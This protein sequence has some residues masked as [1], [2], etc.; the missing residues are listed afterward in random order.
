MTLSFCSDSSLQD[1]G[2]DEFDAVSD[3]IFQVTLF[4]L[5]PRPL[6]AHFW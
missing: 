1:E 3:Y 5:Y 6:G 4:S 2:P